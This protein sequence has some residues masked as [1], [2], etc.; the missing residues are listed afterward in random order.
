ML[1]KICK[2]KMGIDEIN[3]IKR[4]LFKARARSEDIEN[5]QDDPIIY[6]NLSIIHTLT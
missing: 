5:N 1:N 3:V 6:G 4:S 2:L